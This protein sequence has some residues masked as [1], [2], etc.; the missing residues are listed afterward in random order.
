MTQLPTTKDCQMTSKHPRVT[1]SQDNRTSS[2]TVYIKADGHPVGCI[3]KMRLSHLVYFY[4]VRLYI[5][6]P[7]GLPRPVDFSRKFASMDAVKT[8][9]KLAVIDAPARGHMLHYFSKN[10]DVRTL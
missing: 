10:K 8:A 5:T 6:D 2:S 3:T 4:R 1:F 7:E 9:A